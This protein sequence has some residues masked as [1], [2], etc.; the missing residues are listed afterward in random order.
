MAGTRYHTD[1]RTVPG[2]AHGC[3]ELTPKSAGS[4]RERVLRTYAV[5][6]GTYAG[7]VLGMT[8]V[9]ETPAAPAGAS[10][11]QKLADR[12]FHGALLFNAALTAF[13][14]IVYV[15]GA[16]TIFFSQYAITRAALLRVT[17]GFLVFSVL[18]GLVLRH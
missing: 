11:R 8:R 3:R 14:V 15:T 4:L 18:W 17:F 10:E 12:I 6:P 5:G 13:W 7:R 2:T 16:N 9:V 1:T